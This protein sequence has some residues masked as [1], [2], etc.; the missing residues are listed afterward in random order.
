MKQRTT[1]VCHKVTIKFCQNDAD[2]DGIGDDCDNCP[3]IK[4][5]SQLDT[6]IDGQ[7]DACES[8]SGKNKDNK[9]PSVCQHLSIF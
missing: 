8:D 7:G 6:D 5:P 4:N 3:S 1:S 2:G 9:V